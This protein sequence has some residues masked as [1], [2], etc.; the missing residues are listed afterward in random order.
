MGKVTVVKTFA[1]PKIMYY[2][3]M[4]PTPKHDT[5]QTIIKNIFQ[6]MWNGK[7]KKNQKNNIS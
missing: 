7:A 1:L 2:L 4:L 3:T 6:F 5:I